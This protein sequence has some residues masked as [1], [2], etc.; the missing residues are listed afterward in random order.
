[1]NQVPKSGVSLIEHFAN[2]TDPRIERNK[3][4]K[5]VDIVGLSICGVICGADGW[6]DIEEFGHA[7][8][9]W[10]RTFLELPNGIPSHDTIGRVFAR[11]LPGEFQQS[12][13]SWIHAIS[14][15]TEGQII[16]IDGKT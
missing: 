8:E 4:H 6:T 14:T 11:L 16:A 10:L 13:R 2:L 9:E 1:M 12:F 3:E 5:L 15:A 7:K